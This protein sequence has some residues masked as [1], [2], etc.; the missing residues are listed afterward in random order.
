MSIILIIIFYSCKQVENN[1]VEH[2]INK[3]NITPT[4]YK[5]L[6]KRGNYVLEKST[7]ILLNLSNE[8]ENHFAEHLINSLLIKTGK[9]L[10]IAD[11]FTTDNITNSIEILYGNNKS[12]TSEGYK[13]SVAQNKV[14]IYAN[15]PNGITYA[16]NLFVTMLTKSESN[17]WLTP[18]LTIEDYPKTSI[19]AIY[20]E[21]IDSTDYKEEHMLNQLINYRF[22]YLITNTKMVQYNPT[23]SIII[24]NDTSDL[25]FDWTKN[26]I[27]NRSIHEFYLT[28][29]SSTESSVFKMKNKT[30]LHPDS[31]AL[32]SEAMWSQVKKP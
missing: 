14:K 7:R 12:I 21:F 11:R 18:Q 15:D 5:I 2:S 29:T 20:L 9:K 19:R 31:L 16:S 17:K 3:I 27:E 28:D 6:Y 23:N 22:N 25:T 24:V 8:V 32:L 30:L 10:K 13:I 4:P 1:S 26:L